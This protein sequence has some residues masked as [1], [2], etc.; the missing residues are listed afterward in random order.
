MSATERPR[1]R[2]G[3]IEFTEFPHPELSSSGSGKSAKLEVLPRSEADDTATVIQPM[4]REPREFTL[5]GTTTRANATR[6]DDLDGDVVGLRHARHSG[7][8]YIESVDTD[9]FGGTNNPDDDP[10]Q[11]WYTYRVSLVEVR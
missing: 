3:S 8:V 5:R 9:P 2:L 10:D 4:G 7:D 6:L 11:R 1:T